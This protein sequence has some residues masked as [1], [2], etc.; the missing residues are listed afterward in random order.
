[1]MVRLHLNCRKNHLCHQ[2]SLQRT[3]LEAGHKYWICAE[4]NESTAILLKVKR[5][6]HLKAFQTPKIGLTGMGTWII[7]ATAKM[8]GRRTMMQIWNWTTALS[9][10][11]PWRCGIWVRHGMFLDWFGLYD[12]HRR[13]L[14]GHYWWSIS[15]KQGEIMGSRKSRTECVNVLSSSSI[16]SLTKKFI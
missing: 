16:C 2:L 13:M 6:A 8:T 4:S 9:F 11:I 1:M 3:S 10:Q 15:W 14:K 12:N 7:Q 5:I